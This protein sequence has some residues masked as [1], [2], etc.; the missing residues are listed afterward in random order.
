MFY[1]LLESS[2]PFLTICYVAKFCM[3][4]SRLE[5]EV[6]TEWT[7]LQSEPTSSWKANFA[8]MWG[9]GG[10]GVCK[11]AY[12]T[13]PNDVAACHDSKEPS[14]VGTFEPVLQRSVPVNVKDRANTVC[15]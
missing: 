4:F 3:H 12:K 1:L 9:G 8:K 2:L 10:E 13:L 5:F 7:H 15:H 14:F 6:L 11:Q